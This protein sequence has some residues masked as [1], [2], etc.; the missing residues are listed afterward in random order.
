MIRFVN[1]GPSPEPVPAGS[2]H[3]PARLDRSRRADRRV[4]RDPAADVDRQVRQELHA[5]RPAR[6]RQ[7]GP[8]EPFRRDRGSRGSE[9]RV[10]RGARERGLPHAAGGSAAEDPARV[11]R[12]RQ[13]GGHHRAGGAQVVHAQV[14]G[15]GIDRHRRGCPCRA[16]RFGA[17]GGGPDRSPR[18]GRRGRRRL[19]F[20]TD[21][22][23][24]R[25]PVPVRR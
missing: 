7:D 6:R 9:G 19:R 4:R 22:G 3:A 8:A 5:R 20:R 2:R 16:G 18:C 13:P 1:H 17:A 10:H 15:R 23:G 24:R 12:P 11:E 21:G 25:G 14:A